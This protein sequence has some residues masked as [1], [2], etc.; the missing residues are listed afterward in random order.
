MEILIIFML[1][2]ILDVTAW[3]WGVD[4]TDGPASPEW[5]RRRSSIPEE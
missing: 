1:L 2:L 3:Y 4:S 5:E